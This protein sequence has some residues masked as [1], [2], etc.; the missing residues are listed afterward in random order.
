[1]GVDGPAIYVVMTIGFIIASFIPTYIANSIIGSFKNK[2][3]F[4]GSEQEE[5]FEFNKSDGGQIQKLL[6]DLTKL[7]LDT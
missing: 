5:R 4:E 2:V 7:N 1:M 3:S 6:N